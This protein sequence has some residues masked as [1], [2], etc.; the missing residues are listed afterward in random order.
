[1]ISP[2]LT[3]AIL[4]KGVLIFHRS[5]YTILGKGVLISP[6]L[7]N[8]ILGKGVLMSPRLT[9]SI[10]GKEVL[11]FPRLTYAILG[12]GDYLL[13]LPSISCRPPLGKVGFTR[14]NVS[15]ATRRIQQNI[16]CVIR[17]YMFDTSLKSRIFCGESNMILFQGKNRF[18][19]FFL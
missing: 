14:Q 12:K 4:G 13:G 19:M 1:M 6:R 3:Y 7:T 5:T 10:L 16:T 9:Y 8:E 18:S 15:Y 11:L 2:R 17:N